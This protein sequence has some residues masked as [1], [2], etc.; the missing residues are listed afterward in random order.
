MLDELIRQAPQR[1]V[2]HN[3]DTTVKILVRHPR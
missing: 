1:E 3:D 2:L